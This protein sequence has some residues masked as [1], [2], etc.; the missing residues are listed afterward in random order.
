MGSYYITDDCIAC[1]ECMIVCEEEAI[2]ECGEKYCIDT[3]K[4]TD[5]GACEPICPV[6]AIVRFK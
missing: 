4:C 1:A 2:D 5:C 6:F 3:S